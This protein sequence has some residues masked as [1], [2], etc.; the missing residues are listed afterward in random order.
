MKESAIFSAII[1]RQ[2]L[3]LYFA[4]D[5]AFRQQLEPFGAERPIYGS[6]RTANLQRFH[7]KY[8]FNKYPY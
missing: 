2:L 3:Q 1:A 4:G 8:L 6:Y 7:F 5:G